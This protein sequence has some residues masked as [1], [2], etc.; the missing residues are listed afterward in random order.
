MASKSEALQLLRD[1]LGDQDADFREG[2]WEAIDALVNQGE[3][4]LVVERTGWG[5][6][7]VYFISARI[8]RDQGQGPT[9]I[10]SPLLA[11]MRNQVD[12]ADGLGIRAVS[13]TSDNRSQWPAAR[14]AILTGEAD[15]LLISPERLAND[16]FVDDVLLPL[17]QR[18]GLLVVDEAHCISDWGHDFRPDYRRMASVLARMRP[19]LPILG[20]TATA[21]NRVIQ[22]VQEQL[23]NVQIQ[24]GPL[25]RRSLALQ[26][27]VMPTP[28]ARLAWLAEHIN[29]LPGTGIIY[30]LTKRDARHVADW[31]NAQGIPVKAYYSG[32]TGDNGEDT[33]SYREHL[34]SQLLANEL[35]ALVSTNALGM[36]YDKPDLGFVIHYQAPGSVVAYYQQVGRAGRAIDHA[37]GVVMSGTEDDD[38]HEFFRRNAFPNE[39]LVNRVLDALANS[40]GMTV[41]ELE[42]LVNVRNGVL[43]HLLKFLSVELPSPVIK[44]GSKWQRTGVP[45]RLDRE[46]IVRLTQQRETEWHELLGYINEKGCLMEYLARS[47][48]DE[49]AESC[50]KCASCLG[51]PVVEST[52]SHEVGVA[53]ALFIRH[54]EFELE[55]AKQ[56]PSGAFSLYNFP[57]GNI[58][59]ALRAEE[60]RVLSR[61]RDAGWGQLVADGKRD[62]YFS[63]ELVGAVTEMLRERWRPDPAPQWVTC[64]P[65]LNHPD[66]VPDYARRLAAALGLPFAPVVT[67]VRE[68]RPQKEQ[69]NRFHQCSNLD[70]VFQVDGPLPAG[71]VLLVDDVV[72]SSWTLT[73]VSLLLKQFQRDCVWPLALASS[74]SGA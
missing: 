25:M 17:G 47:L 35:K 67:K 68:N 41:R 74:M 66:L 38:I 40:D 69:E 16:E 26:T 14:Q 50:G 4:R 11:L 44:A 73:V 10:V 63:D 56:I 32:V 31:L 37:V 19:N 45:Y 64:V 62:G 24:R 57:I 52:F 29:D 13:I 21:N 70:G 46:R 48:D 60:G 23:G 43:E 5:K 9:L 53:A 33:A 54:A 65:S 51:T 58:P 55:C 28:A 34:E 36:G 72:D 15:I 2:Q 6:S 30:T 61:W 59:A 42:P 71:P 39:G 20:T 1:G 12:A 7:L 18:V 3:R 49:Y 27:V 22:D 8:L